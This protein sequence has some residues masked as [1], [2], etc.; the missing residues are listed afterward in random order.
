MLTQ[1]APGSAYGRAGG[2]EKVKHWR[3]GLAV[4]LED[5]QAQVSCK[6]LRVHLQTLGLYR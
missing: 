6:P 2:S 3:E 4:K 1:E 5:S